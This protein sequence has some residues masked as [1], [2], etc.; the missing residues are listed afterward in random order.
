MKNMLTNNIRYLLN[1][2]TITAEEL[3]KITGHTSTGLVAMWKNGTRKMKTEDA[4]K[5]AIHL[6]ITIDELVNTDLSNPK[7]DFDLFIKTIDYD[8]IEDY[9]KN[10]KSNN[11]L[12]QIQ[13]EELIILYS[14]SDVYFK[15]IEHILSLEKNIQ[16]SIKKE[17]QEI[18]KVTIENIYKNYSPYIDII[19]LKKNKLLYSL[20]KYISQYDLLL[21]ISNRFD[22]RDENDNQIIDENI[23]LNAIQTYLDN[24]FKSVNNKKEGE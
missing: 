6:N 15:N 23:R 1:S 3:L 18:G 19:Y 17:K 24:L 8:K 9:A 13:I 7:S 12:K 14:N 2:K 10:F 5:L 11:L 22:I 4:I 20:R 16:D 21:E